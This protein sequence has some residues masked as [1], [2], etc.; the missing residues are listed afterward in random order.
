MPSCFDIEGKRQMMRHAKYSVV[1]CSLLPWCLA[2]CFPCAAFSG[3]A[4]P[5][6]ASGLAAGNQPLKVVCFGDSVTGVYYHTGGRRAYTDMVGIA[7][8]G[9]YPGVSISAI[10]AGISGHTTVD[11]L[12]RIDKDVL[13]HKPDLVTIMFGLN[14]MTRVPIDAYRDNLVTIVRKCR[15]VGAEV[16]LCTPNSVR[17]TSGRPT[18]KLE[19]YVAAV[20]EVAMI[21]EAHLVDCYCAFE[22]VR[23]AGEISW[24]FL[25]SDEIHPNMD[26]HKLIA[27]TIAEAVL[28]SPVSL[29]DVGPLPVAIPHTVARLEAGKPIR[30]LAM[31]P[32]DTMLPAAIRATWPEANVSTTTWPTAEQ[33]L[34][35]IEAYSKGVREAKPD[36]VFVAVPAAVAEDDAHVFIQRFSWVLN[37]SIGFGKWQWD[38]V[39][40]PPSLL[41]AN[42]NQE[43]QQQD[44]RARR[45][46]R[47]QDL[48]TV[49]R[50]PEYVESAEAILKHWLEEQRFLS[51][52]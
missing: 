9:K 36:L 13:A 49:Q 43:E 19:E 51:E 32:Y 33:S 45:L 18:A 35:D 29:A 39:A 27:E 3:S 44:R 11:A 12:A 4:T 52:K 46:I 25:M 47:A 5:D 24:A 31:P 41:N 40:A 1:M 16:L 34:A 8:E 48:G 17:D 6:F 20:R 30:V 42:L 10:N 21:E 50:G 2:L 15:A 7:L 28:G 23:A 14:D 38:C 22:D 26:G 37:N